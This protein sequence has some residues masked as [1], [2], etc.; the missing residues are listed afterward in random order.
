[1]TKF[2]LNFVRLRSKLTWKIQDHND[3]VTFVEKE[4]MNIATIPKKS[5]Q[6]NYFCKFIFHFLNNIFTQKIDGSGTQKFRFW[7]VRGE[8]GFKES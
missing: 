6:G 7:K 1:M 5:I 3:G 4:S 2:H 8:R